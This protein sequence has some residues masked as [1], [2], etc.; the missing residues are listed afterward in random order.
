MIKKISISVV[1]T[2]FIA[3]TLLMSGCGDSSPETPPGKSSSST[4]FGNSSSEFTFNQTSSTSSTSSVSST[5][6][7][8]TTTS[9]SSQ[10]ATSTG[11][12][13]STGGSTATT[14]SVLISDAYVL[15]ATVTMGGVEANIEVGEGKYEWTNTANG[16]FVVAIRATN[17]LNGNKIADAADAY[18]PALKAPTGYS[19][20]NPFTTMLANGVLPGD[21]KVAYPRAEFIASSLNLV[22]GTKM[23]DFDVVSKGSTDLELAKETLKAALTLATEQVAAASAPN[24]RVCVASILPGEAKDSVTG[25]PCTLEAGSG[26]TSSAAPTTPDFINAVD[27]V[28]DFKDIPAVA[29]T[30]FDSI[31]GNYVVP[32]K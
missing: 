26:S 22:N 7:T 14:T 21:M 4:T 16:A 3:S 12:S 17:D 1:T 30:Q 24:F 28:T 13:S 15:N 31:L 27:A 18:A 2:A 5:S 25:L 11:A 10:A 6:S 23:Y 20:I 19:N 8:A 9:T 29:K 32:A